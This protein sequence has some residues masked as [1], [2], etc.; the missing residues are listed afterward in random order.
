MFSIIL[1]AGRWAAE[2][3]PDRIGPDKWTRDM[4][5]EYVG[6]TMRATMGQYAGVNRDRTRWGQ[7]LSALGKAQH[8]ALVWSEPDRTHDVRSVL[9]RLRRKLRTSGWLIPFPPK[10]RGVRLVRDAT[11][12]LQARTKPDA[13]EPGGLSDIKSPVPRS[14]GG[15]GS[16]STDHR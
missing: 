14:A 11:E 16:L 13:H 15:R 2:K 10:G 1:V 4:A 3:H 7:P 5:A 8:A 9:Y 12:H 6:D